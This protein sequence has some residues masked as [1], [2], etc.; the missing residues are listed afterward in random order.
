MKNYC[1]RLYQ[2][3]PHAKILLEKHVSD[4]SNKI[5]LYDVVKNLDMETANYD[6]E[7]LKNIME[8]V[9]G[10][11]VPTNGLSLVKSYLRNK[12]QATRDN[13]ELAFPEH[14]KGYRIIKVSLSLIPC[15]GI[16]CRAL[17]CI[18]TQTRRVHWSYPSYPS[19]DLT[20]ASTPTH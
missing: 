8:N 9:W 12:F 1:Y 18:M 2:N 13:K 5:K 15:L 3:E 4:I 17:M 6:I 11:Q 14:C 10:T 19:F 20:H 7:F 16:L